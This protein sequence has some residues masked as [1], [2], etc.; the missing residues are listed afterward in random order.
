[1]H[2]ITSDQPGADTTDAETPQ[3]T[4]TSYKYDGRQDGVSFFTCLLIAFLMS[5]MSAAG[6]LF[7]YDKFVALKISA[8][9]VKG[10]IKQQEELFLAGKINDDQINSNMDRLETLVKSLGDVRS[11]NRVV[12]MGDAILSKNVKIVQPQ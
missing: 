8:I 9:D 3:N 11:G 5:V 12:M 1:M 2:T 10:Y 4:P 7:I 6:T